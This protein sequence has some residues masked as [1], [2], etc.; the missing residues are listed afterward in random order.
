MD[1][2][3]RNNI[4]FRRLKDGGENFFTCKVVQ[5]IVFF[6]RFAI[7]PND[8]DAF[9]KIYYKCGYGFNQRAAYWSCRKS[10]QKGI[11]IYDELI[12]QLSQWPSLEKK[13]F[14][15]KEKMRRISASNPHDAIVLICNY[16]YRDYAIEKELDLGK[17]E[18]LCSLAVQEKTIK[19]LL[20]RLHLLPHLIDNYHCSAENPVILSTIHSAKGLEFD[21]VYIVD[22]YDGSLPH[23]DRETAKEQERIDNYEEERRLFYV[24]I[25]RAKNE[26]YLLSVNECRTGFINEIVPESYTNKDNEVIGVSE[27]SHD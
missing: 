6:L 16:W 8:D 1:L 5:D 13:A 18:I 14:D 17:C 15:F 21:I 10:R 20:E 23:S 2:F 24:A 19:G 3:I 27:A 22:A 7:N 11:P 12:N 26:L 25:T 4:P 9:N